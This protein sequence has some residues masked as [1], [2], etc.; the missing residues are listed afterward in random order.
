MPQTA[1]K[2]AT[3]E[4]CFVQME[5]ENFLSPPISTQLSSWTNSFAMVICLW[6]LVSNTQQQFPMHNR[7]LKEESSLYRELL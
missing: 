6:M 5:L 7:Y 1:T 3:I 2:K 4:N